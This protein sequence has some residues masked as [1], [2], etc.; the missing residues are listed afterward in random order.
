MLMWGVVYQ[1]YNAVFPSFFQELFP[2]RTRVTAFAVS[3][4]LGTMATALLPATYAALAGPTPSG[5]VLVEGTKRTFLPN[6]V[7]N[8][9]T[10]TALAESAHSQV[11]LVVGTFTLVLAVIAT[12]AAFTAQE[13]FKIHMND[14]GE[15]DAQPVSDAEYEQAR[16]AARVKV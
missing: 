6:E 12:I 1:G 9:E 11:L 15:K 7:V 13:T 14:L 10:C 8:G 3:Q 16:A 2:T 5:C 4:N